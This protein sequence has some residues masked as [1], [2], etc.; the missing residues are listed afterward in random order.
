M[1]IRIKGQALIGIDVKIG[2]IFKRSS[3]TVS[4]TKFL[5]AFLNSSSVSHPFLLFTSNTP[6]TSFAFQMEVAIDNSS[7]QHLSN[8][9]FTVELP[10]SKTCLTI[11]RY[12]G[13]PSSVRLPLISWMR[14]SEGGPLSLG[15]PRFT[16]PG[17]VKA[18]T[19]MLFFKGSPKLSSIK[20]ERS[21]LSTSPLSFLNVP[22]FLK[23]ASLNLARNFS[24]T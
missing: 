23:T 12:R 11:A 15:L 10:G 20:N 9:R 4:L 24:S 14:I 19:T 17:N 2:N 5:R 21:K 8:T 16:S 1:F 18:F 22:R 3:L 13:I 6:N 7:I